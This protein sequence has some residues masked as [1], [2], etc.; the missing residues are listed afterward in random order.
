VNDLKVDFADPDSPTVATELVGTSITSGGNGSQVK[1]DAAVY[2]EN[3]FLKFTNRERGYVSCT[4][5]PT[6][7]RADFQVVEEV[8]Q[9]GAPLITRASYVV[10]NGKPGAQ[11]V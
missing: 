2:A 6:E 3:P 1:P 7:H 10:E 11:R 4:V 8:R 9:P 5:T